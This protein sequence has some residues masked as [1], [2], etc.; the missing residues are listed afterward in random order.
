MKKLSQFEAML[1]ILYDGRI[2]HHQITEEEA[3]AI[4]LELA[5]QANKGEIDESKVDFEYI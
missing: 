4:L 2:I 1:N 3:A 5:E